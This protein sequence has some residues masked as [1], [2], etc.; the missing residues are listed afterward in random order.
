MREKILELRKLGYS[1]KKIENELGCAR[2]TIS[3]HCN[4]NKSHGIVSLKINIDMINNIINDKNNLT[5]KEIARKYNISISSVKRHTSKKIINNDIVCL[6]CGEN[7]KYG[8]DK[9]FCSAKCS[10]EHLHKLAYK[11]FIENNDS[12]CNGSY[13]AKNFKDFILKEQDNKCA[14][15]NSKPMWMNK[16]LV[17]VLDH[18]DGDASNNKRYNLRL[19]CPN[20]DSQTS[21]FKSKTKHSKRRDY[22]KENIIKKYGGNLAG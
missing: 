21:T 16:K 14:V 6:N 12:F 4:K 7:T 18:I 10:S 5:I 3:Y 8:K 9:K 15:C 19:I 22:V 17:F 13:S 20:C 1:Y 2:S 11:R